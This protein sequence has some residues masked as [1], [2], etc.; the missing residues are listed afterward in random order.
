MSIVIIN[1]ANIAR[2]ILSIANNN[3][4]DLPL[5]SPLYT[6]CNCSVCDLEWQSHHRSS[7]DI[8]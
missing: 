1:L 3:Y 4:N 7:G 6:L 5:T 8:S 2:L